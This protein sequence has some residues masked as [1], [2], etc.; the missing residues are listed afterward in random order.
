MSE[1]YKVKDMSLA[2]WGLKDQ[3]VHLQDRLGQALYRWLLPTY[4]YLRIRG[5]YCSI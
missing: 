2:E 3:T 4:E 1:D 5:S